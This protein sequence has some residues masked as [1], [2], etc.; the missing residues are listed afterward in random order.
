MKQN[1]QNS[2]FVPSFI[3]FFLMSLDLVFLT[4]QW[5][6]YPL[7]KAVSVSEESFSSLAHRLLKNIPWEAC[8]TVL[9]PFC[10]LSGIT[11]FSSGADMFTLYH[12]FYQTLVLLKEKKNTRHK[13]ERTS[14]SRSPSVLPTQELEA[15]LCLFVVEWPFLPF[16]NQR[17]PATSV[18]GSSLG[19]RESPPHY[20]QGRQL[21]GLLL[22]LFSC[23]VMSDSLRPHGL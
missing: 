20:V 11:Y 6:C 12:L 21:A 16:L 8:V 19:H 4:G 23:S 5:M 10:H 3:F 1:C 15:G 14:S 22:L 2:P 13:D 7:Q 17:T 9:L 18:G